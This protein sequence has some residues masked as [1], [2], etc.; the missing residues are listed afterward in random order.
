MCLLRTCSRALQSP[1]GVVRVFDGN[2]SYRRRQCRFVPFS[3]S[4][5]SLTVLEQALKALHMLPQTRPYCIC[6]IN[7]RGD[8]RSARSLGAAEVPWKPGSPSP[9][10]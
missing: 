9:S 6:E 2:N 4:M 7:E 1:E 3:K 5:T 10:P 8:G